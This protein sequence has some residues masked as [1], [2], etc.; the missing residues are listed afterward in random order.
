[1]ALQNVRSL[2][3]RG[4]D[5]GFGNGN[6]REVIVPSQVVAAARPTILTRSFVGSV[7]LSSV[8]ATASPWPSHGRQRAIINRNANYWLTLQGFNYVNNTLGYNVVSFPIAPLQMFFLP[9]N[10]GGTVTLSANSA[11]PIPQ[12]LTGSPG[13]NVPQATTQMAL[14]FDLVLE[15]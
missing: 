9:V 10:F 7:D 1:M 5:L 14:T 15:Q 4:E 12:P 13:P 6:S 11:W 8:L 2:L 3:W